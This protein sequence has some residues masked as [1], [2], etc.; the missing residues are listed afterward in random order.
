MIKAC[1]FDLDGTLTETQE[2]IA[3]PINQTLK[4]Y[5]LPEQPV[6]AFN[7]FAGDGIN[8]ALKRALQ[9]S[10]DEELKFYDEGIALCRKWM[11]EDPLYHVKPYPHV[12]E[13]LQ[14]LKQNGIRLAVFSNKPNTSAQNVVKT[15]FGED[16]F[17]HVQ[18]QKE[19][20]PIKPNPAGVFEILKKFGVEKDECLYF[21]DT[22]TDMMTG[23]NAGLYTVG[24]TW[25]FRP[26]KELEEY[27]ADV[28]IDSAADFVT[29]VEQRNA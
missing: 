5:G 12:V 16:L 23:K 14:A 9:A 28:I 10:G 20:V 3:R 22:N 18:G 1:I 2:S 6:E 27:H 25:G 19:G 13:S 26:R 24:V 29:L 21:G 4:H 11:D 7:Y 8:N 15:I 17:D